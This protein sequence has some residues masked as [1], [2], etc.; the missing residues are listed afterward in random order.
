MMLKN[1]KI[2]LLS[3]QDIQNE[4][5]EKETTSWIKLTR[6]LTHEI[7]NSIAPI[8]S[9]SETLAG[10]YLGEDGPRSPKI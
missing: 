2:I 5:D 1:K 9:L 3:V 10:Y 6:V 4:L 8:T 7:M